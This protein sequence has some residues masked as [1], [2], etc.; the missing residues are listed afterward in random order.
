MNIHQADLEAFIVSFLDTFLEAKIKQ[1]LADMLGFISRS[2][3]QTL[4]AKE[5]YSALG[6]SS[7]RQL[8]R[9]IEDGLLRV[10][11][12]VEDRRRPGAE[13]PRYFI[14]LPAVRKR[15]KQPPEK[16]A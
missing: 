13:R 8:Y 4:A 3:P 6:Y 9:D 12:E 11:I 15:L 14:D 2:E 7:I 10:G 5:A 1:T 16:R